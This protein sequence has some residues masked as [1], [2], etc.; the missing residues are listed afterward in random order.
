MNK[1]L[2]FFLVGGSVFL[3]MCGPT[4]Q[5]QNAVCNPIFSTTNIQ[6]WTCDAP[7]IAVVYGNPSWGMTMYCCRKNPGL[8]DNNASLFQDVH[9][10][11]GY[12]YQ[13]SANIAATYI[14]PS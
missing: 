10:I 9:L 13:F 7:S 1:L 4:L 5:A 8:P 3:G 11:A 12:T 14:C 2:W 6:H